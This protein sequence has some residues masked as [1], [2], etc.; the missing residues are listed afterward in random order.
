MT[1]HLHQYQH[2]DS[3][4]GWRGGAVPERCRP[5]WA[6]AATSSMAA[7]WAS[8]RIIDPG[9]THDKGEQ[10]LCVGEAA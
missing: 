8:D 2:D 7:E 9:D 10:S 1:E 4:R 5:E 6:R 3:M